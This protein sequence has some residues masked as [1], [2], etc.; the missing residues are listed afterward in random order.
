MSES[1]HFGSFPLGELLAI[2]RR[3]D[4]N[5]IGDLT[6]LLMPE[7]ISLAPGCWE[8]ISRQA[9]RFCS[10][11][12][13]TALLPALAPELRID[14]TLDAPLR[15]DIQAGAVLARISGVTAQMLSAE[16]T[17]LNILQHLSG[18]ATLTS[19]FVHA[20]S[21]T[22]AK[23]FDTRKTTPG[24][25]ALEK[26]AVRCGGGHNHR[27]GLYDAVLIKDNHL[28]G[29]PI[30]RLA[31]CVFEMLNRI[32]TLPNQPSFIEVECDSIAQASEL[33]KV[34]GID[35]VLLDN[36][37]ID[38][39]RAAVALRDSSG[40]RNKVQ[41]EASGGITLDNVRQVAETGV[42]RIAVGAITHSAPILDLGLDTV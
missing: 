2:A 24:L 29:V 11:E 17:L 13:L 42:E 27:H 4:L 6:A 23:I 8:L 18:I 34:V 39:L 33:F 31:H 7:A 30:D 26:Y 5:E 16:R 37:P 1:A 9:G 3:E 10:T 25:R 38:Q 15:S 19:H 40:L 28:S 22:H 35:I 20:I 21:G 41:L 32:P 14:W 12:L 36:F